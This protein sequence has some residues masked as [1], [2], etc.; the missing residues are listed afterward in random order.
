MEI[1]YSMEELEKMLSH[2]QDQVKVSCDADK[3]V[4]N[5]RIRNIESKLATRGTN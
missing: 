1:K 2:A 5:E 4:W 3:K